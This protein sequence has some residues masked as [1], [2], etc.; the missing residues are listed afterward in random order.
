MTQ[1]KRFVVSGCSSGI[2]LAITAGLL[3]AGHKI[4]GLARHCPD[5]DHENFVFCQTDLLN[6]DDIEACADRIG[7]IDGLIHAAGQLRTS[8]LSELNLA[9]GQLMWQLHLQAG[10]GLCAILSEQ[11]ADGGRIIFIGSRVARGAHS[12]SMY[13]ASKSALSGFARSIALE[14]SPRNIT[15]NIVA[16]GATQT[17]MLSDPARGSTPPRRPPFGRFI[18]PEEVSGLVQFLVSDAASGITGQQI[19]MCGG[20]SL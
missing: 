18:T 3:D 11:I 5:L 16:P 8:G 1:T 7:Q 13:A 15:V 6:P 20:A 19:V 9:D 4:Y 14:L 17:P 12:R 2:G 10:A